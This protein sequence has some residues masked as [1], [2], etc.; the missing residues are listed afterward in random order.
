MR[1]H[2]L[3]LLAAALLPAACRQSPETQLAGSIQG[4]TYHIKLVL[5][6]LPAKPE[7]I[8]ADVEAVFRLVDEK[9]SNWREDSE[10]SRINRNKTTDWIPAAPEI[11]RLI[12][13]ARDV[14]DKTG[15]CY[16]LTVKP[17]FDL[18]GFSKH[19]NR[20]PTDAEIAA[21]RAH[22]GM[23]KLELDLENNRLRKKDPEVQIDLSSIAQGYTVAVLAQ[24]LEA[25]GIRSYLAEVGGEMKVKGTKADGSPWRVAIEKPTPF[26]REVQRV[27]DL[28]E[29]RGTAVMTAGTYRNFFEDQGKTYS[30]ILDPR[31]GRPVT[32]GL[33][34]VSIL[35]EDPTL[36]D[37]WD[38]ALLCVGE[39][40]G[41]R[42]AEAEHLK[43]LFIYRDGDELKERLSPEFSG[44]PKASG[45]G[46]PPSGTSP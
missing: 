20:V 18:W 15:G 32:H 7:E 27:L 8:K 21:A 38:T 6:G 23:D 33:L 39:V 25:R 19:E 17:I 34:S 37:A 43:A 35:H 29:E 28:Q 11:V 40:E 1:L 22:V 46:A 14:G 2:L 9:L 26:A 36:A 30:H 44:P 31:T 16:D 24:L 13:V 41:A 3:P 45:A 12:A 4:T 42:I 10:I 5:D